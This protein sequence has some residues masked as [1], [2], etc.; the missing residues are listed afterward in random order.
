MKDIIARNKRNN[1]IFKWVAFC[2]TLVALLFL[3]T[4]LTD[5]FLDGIKRIDWSFITNYPSRKPARAGILSSIVGTAWIM[6]LTAAISFP[7]GVGAGIYLEEFSKKTRFTKL[8]EINI[9]N[10]AGVPS[11]IYGLLGLGIFVRTFSLERS[12]I[13]GALTL[14]LLILP[15]IITA[16]REALKAIPFSI[17]IRFPEKDLTELFSMLS[18]SWNPYN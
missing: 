4:L 3:A 7:L 9:A 2:S 15:I 1:T 13:S 10:L 18:K 12:L 6:G 17:R 8:I 14:T 16:T 11:I 5:I